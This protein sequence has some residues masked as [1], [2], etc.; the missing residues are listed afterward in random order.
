M[1]KRIAVNLVL[2]IALFFAPWWVTLILGVIASFY[3]SPYYELIV[4]GA[5]FD[6]LYGVT[7]STTFSY[8]VFG[9]VASVVLFLIIER[10]KR[11]LR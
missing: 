3:F 10:V 5:L 11:E 2:I 8:N 4:L 1:F 7:T 9:F 6:I